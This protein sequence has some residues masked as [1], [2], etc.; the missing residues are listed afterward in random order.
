MAL[1]IFAQ[2]RNHN[3]PMMITITANWRPIR[4]RIWAASPQHIDQ[5]Q[6]KHDRDRA[7]ADCNDKITSEMHLGGILGNTTG[8]ALS[9]L[10]RFPIRWNHRIEKESLR[11]KKLEHVRKSRSTFSEHA[12][13]TNQ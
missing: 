12:P 2:P 7:D 10:A 3:M 8:F 5:P 4:Q 9:V 13:G 6:H 1:H 11:F